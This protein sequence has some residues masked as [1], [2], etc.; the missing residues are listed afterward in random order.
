M[1]ARERGAGES[2]PAPEMGR[3]R[4]ARAIGDGDDDGRSGD[5]R[6]HRG[7]TVDG[8]ALD[9]TPVDGRAIEVVRSEEELRTGVVTESAGAV[10]VRKTVESH[11]VHEEVDRSVEEAD[12]EHVPAEEGDSGEIE[13]LPDGSLSIPVFEEKI[14]VEK[15]VVV[16]ERIVIRK[17]TVTERQAVEAE[18]R[19]E[20]VEVD[21]DA[22]IADRVDTSAL[23]EPAEDERSV[24]G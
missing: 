10:R 5:G 7:R 22:A 9:G 21:V 23:S 24:P 13:T 8:R 11:P 14:V 4:G 17:R 1:T 16:R 12:V 20:R 3:L 2:H 19:R 18:L 15:R 6:P